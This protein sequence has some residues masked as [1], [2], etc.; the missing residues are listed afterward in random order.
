MTKTYIEN[1]LK[2]NTSDNDGRYMGLNDL[3]LEIKQGQNS[4]FDD[5][6]TESKV[7][8]RV[9]CLMEDKTPD[10]KDQAVKWIIRES[11]RVFVIDKLF[12]YSAGENEELRY[13]SAHA[14]KTITAEL[15]VED[16][17]APKA[18]ER[19]TPKL[20]LQ[21]S[22][23][24][25]PPDTL[26]EALAILSIL[27]TRFSSHLYDPN[28][29]PAPLAVS[30][31]LLLH[32]RKRAI[33]TLA[34]FLS[35]APTQTFH[36]LFRS[37]ILPS[38]APAAK[39]EKRTTVQ[40]IISVA[41]QSPQKVAPFLNE[42]VTNILTATSK[43]DE[44]LRASCLQA[45]ETLV[46]RCP[47][48][49]APFLTH[50]IN[51][52][53]EFIKYD[54]NYIDD[55][56][57][58][59]LDD[60]SDDEDTSYKIRR[61]AT[62]LLSAV[63]ETRPELLITLY[64]EVSPVLISRFGDR[65]E[66]VRVEVWATYSKLLN[67]TAT[68][69]IGISMK[70]N[71]APRGIK[72]KRNE[73][74][75][76][77]ETP[78]TLLSA[79]V[80]S[81]AKALLGQ[82]KASPKTSPGTL[83]AG[84]SLLQQLLT[85]VPEA[86]SGQAAAV[87]AN[88]KVVLSQSSNTTTSSLRVT[89]L[90]FLSRFF[91][92][93]LPST[94]ASSL[95]SLLPTL[96]T[97]LGERDPRLASESF[98]VFSSLLNA[99]KP[100][101]SGDWVE[102]VYNEA[103]TRFANHNTDT[104]V[105]ACAEEVIGD[106][107]ICASDIVKTKNGR[108]WEAMCRTRGRTEGA[109]QVITRVAREVEI[110]DEWVNYFVEWVLGLLGK[111][112]RAGQSDVFSCLD[113]LFRRYRA[114]I[115]AYLP[116]ILI[117]QLKVYIS[118][119]D[120]SL[121][122][123][124]LSILALLLELSP[125]VTFP[126]VERQLLKDIYSVSRSPVVSGAVLDALLT[127]FGSLVQA[128][129][130]IATHVVHDLVSCIDK[131]P[132]GESSQ[133]NVAKCVGQVVKSQQSIAAGTIAEFAKHLRPTPKAK[134]SQVV[135]SLLVMGE[136]GRFIDMWAQQDIFNQAIERFSAEQE[137]IRTAASFA[138]GN[139]A[140]GNLQRFLKVIVMTAEMDSQKRL[141]SLYA[142]KEVVT[143]CSHG[144]LE[145]VVDVLWVPLSQN[146]R[147]PEETTRNVAAACLRK[148]ATRNPPR[149]LPQPQAFPFFLPS[150][151]VSESIRWEQGEWLGG[152]S[153]G[154]VFRA[155]NLDS[156][157]DIAVKE[158]KFQGVAGLLNFFGQTNNEANV[159]EMLQHPNVVKYYGT[160]VHHDKV[161]IFEE[162]CP[163][164]LAVLLGLGRVEDEAVVRFYTM[165]MLE[166]LDYLHSQGVVHRD[167][168]PEN[169]LLDDLGG[170]KL[171]DFGA[172]KIP[173]KNQRS[174]QHSYCASD[175]GVPSGGGATDNLSLNGTP[176][177]MSPEVIKGDKRGRHDA[178]DVWSLGCVVLECA[179]GRKPWSNLD[180]LDNEW[181]IMFHIGDTTQPPPL[182][183]TSELSELGIDFIRQCLTIDPVQRPTARELMRHQWILD[184]REA[185]RRDTTAA[186]SA[187]SPPIEY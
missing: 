174:I 61:S 68:Y 109:V 13:L 14:L 154:S 5:Q 172:A 37:D 32:S 24:S 169:I 73:D 175:A 143:H 10:V 117:P 4:F 86:L 141:S 60:Y 28:L 108:E 16:K 65:E 160:E 137:E 15:P 26:I 149:N 166:G 44:E 104:D 23:S 82:L 63:I 164:S 126:E 173:A 88:T 52:G 35:L 183:H 100:V 70:D 138:A 186:Y 161:Y 21:L 114:G 11:Q 184:F 146:S 81:L 144:Q 42:I 71:E 45:L 159:M 79:Q 119:N 33:A 122:S 115:P 85:V 39:V 87:I 53:K 56:D 90:S 94:F 134:T 163:G 97:S 38:L 9:L 165:Q 111:S 58:G 80:P 157:S 40:L 54:P 78:L 179:T 25:I 125:A 55:C 29:Q 131:A 106:L 177:Y 180:N 130:Q 151:N 116:H 76:M 49:V 156:D 12:E 57:D 124:A 75:D 67:Q 132:K 142:L 101:R 140:V 93:H 27:V 133:T 43:D 50:I 83:Q 48:E 31:P 152:G 77:E 176:I 135:L 129:M 182:P 158:I 74:A 98:C 150:S 139:I 91:S 178:I 127:F 187:I 102:L 148:L 47:T 103:N 136:V 153:S 69:R 64:R 19:L 113:A 30:I 72:Q 155:R 145:T 89:C 2:V 34:Q 171:I 168:K 162:F 46:L 92:T 110:G 95:E 99:S 167:I 59:E 17:I 123:Q 185:L 96:L 147:S 84:F 7:L 36:N 1:V 105:R 66:I 20:L 18:C 128:D 22:D 6:D 8:R 120:I 121:L 107:W 51:S 112:G 3:L 118:T 170:I 62:K 181:A 41:R